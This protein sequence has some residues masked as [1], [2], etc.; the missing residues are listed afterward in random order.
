MAL[1]RNATVHYGSKSCSWVDFSD[2][3]VKAA[4]Q[5]GTVETTAKPISSYG[6]SVIF[7]E[8]AR[9]LCARG[10]IID[11]VKDVGACLEGTATI[12]QKWQQLAGWR[13]HDLEPV[14]D[15]F[16]RTIVADRTANRD[17]SPSWYARACE[18]A[19]R[20]SGTEP[21]NITDLIRRCQ[22]SSLL[23]TFLRRVQ[24]VIWNCTMFVTER[25]GSLGMGPLSTQPGDLIYVLFGCSVPIVLR[26]QT[27]PVR[28]KKGSEQPRLWQPLVDPE[29]NDCWESRN[30]SEEGCYEVVGECFAN[31][32]MEGRAVERHQAHLSAIA[33]VNR[34]TK[35]HLWENCGRSKQGLTSEYRVK[36]RDPKIQRASGAGG[37]ESWTW[38]YEREEWD[39]PG[40]R[41]RRH[42]EIFLRDDSERVEDIEEWSFTIVETRVLNDSVRQETKA[43]LPDTF[44]FRQAIQD[45]ADEKAKLNKSMYPNPKDG[46]KFVLL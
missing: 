10:L 27:P 46:H 4:A 39:G 12:P 41:S 1:A 20:L 37:S 32:W 6:G 11:V 14:P 5:G 45:N 2:A 43:E 36:R 23:L 25:S 30:R 21:I 13:R 35:Q 15:P 34:K 18:H 22:G 19:A 29:R 16:W 8:P 38:S 42:P 26:K 3:R 40:D 24:A 44:G 17:N 7:Y 9:E 28:N 33:K 31:G